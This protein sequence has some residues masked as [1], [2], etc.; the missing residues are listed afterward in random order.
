[1]FVWQYIHP[2]RQLNSPAI[3]NIVKETDW[4]RLKWVCKEQ[5]GVTIHD[6]GAG[7]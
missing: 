5:E 1:M 7:A 6:W 3:L 4:S 2:G